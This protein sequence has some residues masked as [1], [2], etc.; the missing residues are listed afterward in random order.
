MT[1]KLTRA[2]M[3]AKI[4][5][6]EEKLK[7]LDEAIGRAMTRRVDMSDQLAQMYYARRNA[8]HGEA[9]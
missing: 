2:A 6:Q 3:D 5:A 4:A 9:S 1:R 7:R 8:F